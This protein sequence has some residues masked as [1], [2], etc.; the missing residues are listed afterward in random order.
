M[1]RITIA[2][3]EQVEELKERLNFEF[4]H[5]VR[6]GVCVDVEI[7]TLGGLTFLECSFDEKVGSSPGVKRLYRHYIANA[8]SDVIVNKWEKILI[9]RFVDTHYRYFD[10][11]E[12]RVIEEYAVRKFHLPRSRKLGVK[13]SHKSRIL[14][15]LVEYLEK[16][17]EIV[18]DGFITFRLKDYLEELEDAV[19]RAVDEFLMEREY[20]EFIRLLKYFVDAQEPRTNQVNVLVNPSGT[21]Q[22]VDDAHKPIDNEYLDNHLIEMADTEI[23][24]EDLLVSALITIAP[25]Q[26]LIH[27]ASL[28]EENTLDTL[29]R[30][31]GNRLRTCPGCSLCP[32]VVESGGKD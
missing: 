20:R 17:D 24:Y 4:Q 28:M 5:L 15:R 12:R 25:R 8:V 16:A 31:F 27:A 6:E 29:S 11:D 23:D 30:V 2:A 19:E 22:M 21:F 32:D 3:G 26:I 13:I 7:K 14:N 1:D 10:D 18:L 9:Q